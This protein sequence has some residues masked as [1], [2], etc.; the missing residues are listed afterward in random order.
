M[1]KDCCDMFKVLG[2]GTRVRIIE[3]LKSRGPLGAKDIAE[4]LLITPAAVSQ[5]L[6]ILRQA[7]FVR[8][9]R[10]G[11]YIPYK[12]DEQGMENCCRMLIEVCTC[13]TGG[14]VG[15]R[16]KSSARRSLKSLKQYKKELEKELRT[17]KEAISG[18]D[19]K[20]A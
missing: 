5:H 16:E 8:S 4:R 11:Y 14:I 6:K 7:G 12:I 15:I 3:L 20:E 13:D 19:E 9:E 1:K 10:Q 18:I 2:V 17:V